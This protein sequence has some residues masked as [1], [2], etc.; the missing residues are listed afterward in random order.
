M[1]IHYLLKVVEG[2]IMIIIIKKANELQS[3]LIDLEIDSY[4]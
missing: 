3:Y 1:N 4:F 2:H